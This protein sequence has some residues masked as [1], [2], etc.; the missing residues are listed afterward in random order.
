MDIW[1]LCNN[2]ITLEELKITKGD[3]NDKCEEEEGS[4]PFHYICFNSYSNGFDMEILKYCC[5]VMKADINVKNSYEDTPFHN[6]CINESNMEILKYCCEV[7]KA[8]I[9]NKN[10][11]G[12]TP[13]HNICF[14]SKSNGFNIE[15]LRYCCEFLKADINV[16]NINGYTPF[17][18]L[19]NLKIAH[20]ILKYL[21]KNNLLTDETIKDSKLTTKNKLR[22][23][24][25]GT[26]VNLDDP[27]YVLY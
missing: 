12:D 22:Y 24:T 17:D 27:D 26:M 7:L 3:I 20:N 15:M 18:Y 5:D 11:D 13:F 23:F 10:F 14:Y 1:T 8:D 2:K 6:I 19:C 16:K 25:E 21:G 9:N 4:T